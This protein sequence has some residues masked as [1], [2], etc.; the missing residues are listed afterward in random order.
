MMLCYG[1]EFTYEEIKGLKENEE[2]KDT[3]NGIG[4]DSMPNLW[5]EMGFISC[6][7]YYDQE[8]E[9]H[10]YI[11][12]KEIQANMNLTDFLKQ[13]NEEV[14]KYLKEQCTKYN[15]KYTEPK[16]LCKANVY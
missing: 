3:A 7:D 14:K 4:C 5:Q 15:L 11:I 13:I 16:I 6:S 9:Y 8:E 12:G 10:N 1:I 2:F